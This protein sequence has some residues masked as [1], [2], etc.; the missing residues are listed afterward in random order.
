MAVH[1]RIYFQPKIRVCA[2]PRI[3]YVSDG[4][5]CSLGGNIHIFVYKN[6]N[7]HALCAPPTVRT[8]NLMN[9]LFFFGGGR[10]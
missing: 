7:K 9:V 6:W 3:E 4:W 10:G 5:G 8:Y 2:M 1:T